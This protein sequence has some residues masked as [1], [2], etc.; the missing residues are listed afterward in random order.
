MDKKTGRETAI[1]QAKRDQ[2]G[3]QASS[4]ASETKHAEIDKMRR[5]KMS[6]EKESRQGDSHE[7]TEKN[8]L[9]P[10]G[11]TRLGMCAEERPGG[12]K[13]PRWRTWK[14]ARKGI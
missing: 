1:K 8:R 9:D 6:K 5:Q 2:A 4:R 13:S 11:H 7:K 10:F 14:P 3:R 12:M